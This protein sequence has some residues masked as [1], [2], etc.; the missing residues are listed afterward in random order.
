MLTWKGMGKMINTKT[1]EQIREESEW[2]TID[3]IVFHHQLW[4]KYQRHEN[5]VAFSRHL[6][7]FSEHKQHDNLDQTMDYIDMKLKERGYG[8][9]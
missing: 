3:H 8:I 2:V 9:K 6:Q 7:L 5:L 4:H 1:L